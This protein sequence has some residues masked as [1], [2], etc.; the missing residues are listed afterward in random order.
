MWSERVPERLR[1]LTKARFIRFLL[2]GALN[3][4]FGYGLFALLILLKVPYALA[5]LLATVA[6]IVFN[7]KS[8]GTLV[9]GSHD[10][11]LIARFFA[12]YAVCYGVN[13]VPLWWGERAG[14]SLLLV[15]AVMALPMAA[16]SFVLNR[17]FVFESGAKLAR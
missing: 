11:R 17:R 10:N 14:I 2:V 7:F 15:G 6:G 1:G 16:L 5:S 9:F 8:Y 12:V 4:A 13:L 3:T